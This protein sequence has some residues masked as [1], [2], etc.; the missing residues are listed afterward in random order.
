MT[1]PATQRALD[2]VHQY[3][4]ALPE[5][6]NLRTFLCSP[7]QITVF[8]TLKALFDNQETQTFLPERDAHL[9]WPMM[10]GA[11]ITWGLSQP[12]GSSCHTSGLLDLWESITRVQRGQSNV[13]AAAMHIDF[14]EPLRAATTTLPATTRRMVDKELYSLTKALVPWG[15]F[16]A[17][18]PPLTQ[19]ATFALG[20]LVATAN[21]ALQDDWRECIDVA[22]TTMDDPDENRN[23]LHA[24]LS[25]TMP[26]EQKYDAIRHVP[27]QFWTEEFAPL[28]ILLILPA[29]EIDRLPKLPWTDSGPLNL[30]LCTLYCPNVLDAL[31]RN[32]TFDWSKSTGL[33]QRLERLLANY[34]ASAQAPISPAL[35]DSA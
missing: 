13:K 3:G 6:N 17:F 10:F 23:W 30:Q 12:W 21:T 27:T 35:F 28:A 9:V 8:W 15:Q 7:H 4:S 24:A 25:S 22:L 33:I 2:W 29:R 19:H 16:S 20:E 26:Q 1:T 11:V 32:T 14:L 31:P 18:S 5:K 34:V